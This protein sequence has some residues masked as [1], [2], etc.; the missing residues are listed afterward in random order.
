VR[1]AS[2]RPLYPPRLWMRKPQSVG[3]SIAVMGIQHSGLPAASADRESAATT[4]GARLSPSHRKPTGGM[5]NQEAASKD[6]L[7]PRRS[8]RA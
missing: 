3:E 1:R 8:N 5:R 2:A 6:R 4:R 7:S